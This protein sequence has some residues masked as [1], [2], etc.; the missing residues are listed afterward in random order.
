MR[1]GRKSTAAGQE[2]VGI[3]RVGSTD[4][5]AIK[6]VMRDRCGCAQTRKHLAPN[7]GQRNRLPRRLRRQGHATTAIETCAVT[8]AGIARI[9]AGVAA[10]MLRGSKD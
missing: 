9:S 7:V 8:A 6:H 3:T 4:R 1:G 2:M 5:Q 10:S